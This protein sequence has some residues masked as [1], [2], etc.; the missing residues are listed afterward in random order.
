MTRN[1]VSARILPDTGMEVLSK[2]EVR[3]LADSSQSGLYH[4]FRRCAL[5]VLT[6]DLAEIHYDAPEDSGFIRTPIARP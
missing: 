1:T 2:R 6:P 4:L 3:R 5:A